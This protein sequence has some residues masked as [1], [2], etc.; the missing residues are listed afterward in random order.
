M[1]MWFELKFNELA[2]EE[3]ARAL[4][5]LRSFALRHKPIASTLQSD[6][7]KQVYYFTTSHHLKQ[8]VE[9]IGFRHVY[10]PTDAPPLTGE[11]DERTLFK[12][13]DETTQ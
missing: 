2:P 3:M 13:L 4:D 5:K 1:K 10:P 6:R 9:D 11:W 12:H 8:E 7:A